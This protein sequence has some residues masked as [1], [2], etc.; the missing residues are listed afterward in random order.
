VVSF[1]IWEI[2]AGTC[3]RT[4]GAALGNAFTKRNH[5]NPCFWIALWNTH[6]YDSVISGAEVSGA[7]RDQ[8]VYALN[9]RSGRIRKTTVKNVHYDKN[10]G[11]AKLTPASM[12][13]FAARWFPEKYR[14]LAKYV[15]NHPETL[16][17]DF[18]DILEAVEKLGGYDSIIKAARLGGVSSPEHKGLL[19]A[20]LV[21]HAMRSH[22]MMAVM[23][24][25]T[26]KLGLDKFEY[27]WLIKNAWGNP[28][29]LARAGHPLAG[30]QWVF[31]RT[32][33]HCFPLCDSP[34]MIGHRRVTAILSPKLLLMIHLGK[35][36]PEDHWRI[37]D[38]ISNGRLR[39]F[40]RLAILNSYKDIIFHEPKE[41]AKWR[42][43]PEF[44]KRMM[45][46]GNPETTNRIEAEAASRVMWAVSG[47]GM[48]GP[49]FE[50]WAEAEGQAYT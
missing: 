28:L 4:G 12:K 16:Y 44:R 1:R 35:P 38:G 7:A 24:S 23:M 17:I 36:S 19:T 50:A 2:L 32:Q 11:V 14:S 43:C 31:Y 10:M 20:T 33:D 26:E 21:I 3:G 49:D 40:R 22:E 39:Q 6:Y 27:F 8:R 9:V 46:L 18:E 41:L 34:I 13:R 5:Y 15:D 25:A 30:A 37:I 48:V 42:E 47:F 45:D 29:V